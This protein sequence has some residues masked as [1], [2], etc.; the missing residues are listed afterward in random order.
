MTRRPAYRY[1]CDYC[2]KTGSSGGHMIGH[3]T[4]CTMN[5]NRICRM[6]NHCEDGQRPIAE[7]IAA[8]TKRETEYRKS[9]NGK[10]ALEDLRDAASGC[11]MCMLAALRQSRADAVEVDEEGMFGVEFGF[12]FKKE[13]AEF[14]Q[15]VNA[16]ESDSRE[17]RYGD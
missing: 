8:L 2:G 9:G 15:S 10:A 4:T 5:P 12:D 3:E 1:R 16:A 11:P 13:L 6:H 17:S 7:L 14:W